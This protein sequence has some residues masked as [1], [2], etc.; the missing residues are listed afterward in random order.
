MVSNRFLVHTIIRVIVLTGTIFLLTWIWGDS[1]LIFN[2]I[3]LVLALIIE[4]AELIRFTNHTNRELS[5]FLLAIRF[6]DFSATYKKTSLGSSFR[7]L[8][9]SMR[10]IMDTYKEVKIE[11]EG[12]FRLLE[13]LVEQ[14]QVGIISLVDG[15]VVLI[16]ATAQH[17][18]RL[19]GVKN[20]RLMEQLRPAFTSEVKSLGA[21]GRRLV[22]MPYEQETKMLAVELSSRIILDKETK[23]ITIQDINSEIEQKEIEAWHKLIRILTHEIMNSITPISSLTETMQSLLMDPAGHPRPL[24]N[25]KEETIS[26]LIFSLNTIH[27][28][29]EGLLRF[30]EDYRRLTRVPRPNPVSISLNEFL[31]HIQNLMTGTLQR[32]GITF[33]VD[34]PFDRQIKV[35]PALMEQVLIN[36]ITNSMNAL[37]ESTD[38][39]IRL[40]AYQND[41]NLNLE[42]SDTGKGIPENELKD[43]FVP[44]FSTRKNGS[45]IGLSLS[46]QIISQHGGSIK[47]TSVPGSGTKVTIT[48]MNQFR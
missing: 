28:R 5:R 7:D 30:V 3:I 48:L 34:S 20:W 25:L 12:Q 23:L 4:T 14:I 38:K 16:N 18:L 27:N 29:S 1:R 47:V 26:D 33:E 9:E 36:L 43:I 39:A 40:K 15:E 31:G 8:Q 22:E 11:K 21:G 41:A 35:D 17:L 46:K 32:Q 6:N 24:E 13:N 37:E 42:I 44:F 19:E 2:Q 45:G 10:I